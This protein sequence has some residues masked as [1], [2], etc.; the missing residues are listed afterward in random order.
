MSSQIQMYW[1]VIFASILCGSEAWSIPLREE[2]R[3]MVLDVNMILK[4][5]FAF[6]RA[7]VTG[8]WRRLYNE[9]LH[10]FYS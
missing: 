7:Q 3:P 8:D 2:D 1:T 4:G 9:E 5:V 6:K 10:N